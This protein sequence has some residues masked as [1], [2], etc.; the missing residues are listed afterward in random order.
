[1]VNGQ[2][3]D[4]VLIDRPNNDPYIVIWQRI[5]AQEIR[6]IHYTMPQTGEDPKDWKK[7]RKKL[8]N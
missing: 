5:S 6:L 2:V 3:R 7:N 8:K 1:M 4:A